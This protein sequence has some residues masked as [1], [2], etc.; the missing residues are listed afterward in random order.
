LHYL[1][2]PW[3]KRHPTCPV[4]ANFWKEVILEPH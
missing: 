4:R 1:L 3:V 2:K